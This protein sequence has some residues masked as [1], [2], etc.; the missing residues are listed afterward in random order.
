[1]SQWPPLQCSEKYQITLR[2]IVDNQCLALNFAVYFNPEKQL[3]YLKACLLFQ[4]TLVCPIRDSISTYRLCPTFYYSYILQQILLTGTEIVKKSTRQQE[5]SKTPSLCHSPRVT[6]IGIRFSGQ[7]TD[8]S[9]VCIH[10][11]LRRS[12]S[13]CQDKAKLL[14][15][16][17]CPS[18]KSR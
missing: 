9:A 11:L 3:A 2:V 16:K 18:I 7:N 14:H 1:M 17:P 10:C 4:T 5:K 13:W 12:W 15:A 8:I 6:G